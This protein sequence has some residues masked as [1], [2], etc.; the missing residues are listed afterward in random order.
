MLIQFIVW[1]VYLPVQASLLLIFALLDFLS[2]P[3]RLMR[4]A[5]SSPCDPLDRGS[6]T[7]V[8]LNWNGRH[9][10]EESLP[11]LEKAVRKC[12]GS[13]RILVVDNGSDDD[14]VEWLQSHFPS[15]D[16]LALDRN[17]GFAEGNNIGVEASSSDIVVLLNNDMI[18]EEDFLAPLIEPFGEGDVFAVSSQIFF[19]KGRRREETGNT[20]GRLRGGYFELRHDPLTEAHLKRPALPALWAGGGSS[21]FHR[22]RFLKLGGFSHIFSP[23]YVE[24]ADL[25]YRA[26]RRGWRVLLAAESRVLHKHRSSSSTRFQ[27]EKLQ[28]IIEERKLWYFWKNFP[29]SH[30][31][32]HFLLFGFQLTRIIGP[33]HYLAALR[34]L[35]GVLWLRALEPLPL[36]PYQQIQKW[37]ESPVRYLDHFDADR[38]SRTRVP[39][40]L[41]ILVVSAY[42]PHL[43]FHGGA[44]RVFQLLRQVAG[45]HEVSVITFVESN[46]EKEEAAQ[47]RP[48]CNRVELVRRAA[49]EPVSA[50]PYEPFEEFNCPEFRARLEQL[51]AQEDFDIVHFEWT[52]MAQLSD[53]FPQT[54][55]LMTEIEVNYAARQTEVRLERRPLKRL[56]KH[57][58]TLQTLYREIEQSKRVDRVV[59][60]TDDDRDYLAGYLPK[61]SLAVVNTGV[62]TQF[63][64]Y[65]GEGDIDPNA[66]VFVG[67]FRHGPNIDAMHYFCD[68]V[69]PSILERCPEAHL[70]IVGSSPP[71]DIRRLDDGRHVTVT[72]FVEDIRDYYYKAQVVVVPLRTGVGIRGKVLE[73][74]SAGRAVVATSLACQGIRAT[75]GENVLIADESQGLADWTASLLAH[76][77]FAAHLGRHGRMT[78]E[79]HYD[80]QPLGR[81]MCAVY[82]EL[83]GLES[84]PRLR[85]VAEPAGVS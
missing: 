59:C 71:K 68:E 76:P 48:F 42:L 66:I 74:W 21:A 13:H 10:L 43:G 70:Y 78:V 38:A 82:E 84:E 75:H 24:D 40:H 5:P 12:H 11:P 36:Y 29:L 27:Q 65:R 62:E 9:L 18:V 50:Y 34:R 30:L 57:Y 79:E 26:W 54:P 23:V 64:E 32:R 83:L 56:K 49:F 15:I 33:V 60:V 81:Q 63:F 55:K 69:F 46:R 80:W 31:V 16:V 61:S 51:L 85:T 22:E 20:R 52:Q 14:S 4:T 35:P 73:A 2:F 25:S 3:V 7:I 45:R 8:V 53:L 67:A 19:P 58:D 17:H 1:L 39:H 72:G 44:G 28:S 37:L 6:C 77:E 41:R 47:I